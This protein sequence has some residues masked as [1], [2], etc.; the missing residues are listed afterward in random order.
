VI[1]YVYGSR[2]IKEYV[3]SQSEFSVRG[4]WDIFIKVITPIVLLFLVVMEAKARIESS[5]GGYPRSAEFIGGWLVV[6]LIPV[7][8]FLLMKIKRVES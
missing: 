4:W 6:I 8:G 2:K 1:G 3:N 7:V 5:Y